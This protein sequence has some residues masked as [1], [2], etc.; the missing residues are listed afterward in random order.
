MEC[1]SLLYYIGVYIVSSCLAT[2]SSSKEKHKSK[3]AFLLAVL[4]PSIMAGSRYFTGTDYKNYLQIYNEIVRYGFSVTTPN[5]EIGYLFINKVCIELGL[6]YQWVLFVMSWITN[7]YALKAILVYKNDFNSGL[8]YFVYLVCYYQASYNL[9]RQ[10]AAMTISLYAVT[11]LEK[12]KRLE[13]VIYVIV[14]TL[15]HNSAL[16]ILLPMLTY[17]LYKSN[18]PQYIKNGYTGVMCLLLL[19]YDKVFKFVM[20]FMPFLSRY[21]GYVERGQYEDFGV[22]V[23]IRYGYIIIPFLLVFKRYKREKRLIYP[24]II[25]IFCF[26]F[27]L[28]TYSATFSL[29]VRLVY[30]FQIYQIFCIPLLYRYFKEHPHI[31]NDYVHIV[32]KIIV[33]ITVVF[34]IYDYFILGVNATVPYK[35][36]LGI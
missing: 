30:F 14:A 26:V 17:I 9:V 34:W 11:R 35:S 16:I 24:F 8:A 23:F 18:L 10:A 3:M 4:I 19:F 20:N 25:F 7:Y 22:T 31:K 6:G 36:V 2:I 5:L 12:E 29:A 32:S 15:F 27:R 33:L 28:A 13:A 21:A 1:S